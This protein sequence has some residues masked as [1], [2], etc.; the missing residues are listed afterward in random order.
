M[1]GRTVAIA[2]VLV[3]IVLLVIGLVLLQAGKVEEAI[4]P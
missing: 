3:A 2:G 1:N 4:L